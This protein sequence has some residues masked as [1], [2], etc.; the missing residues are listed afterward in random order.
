MPEGH[1]L[2]RR[3]QSL[4]LQSVS[5]TDLNRSFGFGLKTPHDEDV[6]YRQ[7]NRIGAV[8]CGQV[9]QHQGDPL[10]IPLL[11]RLLI[12]RLR[13]HFFQACFRGVRERYDTGAVVAP[14]HLDLKPGG[15]RRRQPR[16]FRVRRH[17]R[18]AHERNPVLPGQR[19][20][21]AQPIRVVVVSAGM[22][23]G[24]CSG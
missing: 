18:P 1:V 4:G 10:R 24:R 14:G 19:G 13:Q 5:T 15:T 6:G 2:R 3:G 16:V 22:V 9:L 20:G 21:S 17:I 23:V 8:V 12:Q 11:K 7:P